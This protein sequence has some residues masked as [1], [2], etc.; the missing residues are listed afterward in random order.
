VCNNTQWTWDYVENH[1]DFPRL[2]WMALDWRKRPPVHVSVAAYLGI[3]RKNA[4]AGEILPA[5]DDTTAILND[6]LPPIPNKDT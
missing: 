1:M 4:G 5:V 2:R 6:L 3:G